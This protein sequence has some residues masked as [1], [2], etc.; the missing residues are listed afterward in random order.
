[1]NLFKS[2]KFACVAILSFI[3]PVLSQPELINNKYS[4]DFNGMS[5]GFKLKTTDDSNVFYNMRYGWLTETPSNKLQLMFQNFNIGYGNNST[6]VTS[7]LADGSFSI[8]VKNELFGKDIEYNNDKNQTILAKKD[9]LKITI[10]M[11]NWN[12]VNPINNLVLDF[13]LSNNIGNSNFNIK[14]NNTI[15]LRVFDFEFET[16]CLV[17]NIEKDV[18]FYTSGNKYYLVFPSFTSDLYYD[19]TLFYIENSNSS[20]KL[21]PNIYLMLLFVYIILISNKY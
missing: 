1:M 12:F 17:D 18:T 4:V 8:N 14:N 20:S 16:K 6:Y 19:P 7:Y 2:L 3:N 10:S 5:G 9:T 15:N 21:I 11:N 13:T